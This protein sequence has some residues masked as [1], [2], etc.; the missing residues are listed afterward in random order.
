MRPDF[1]RGRQVWILYFLKLA[2]LFHLD[3]FV[4]L[5]SSREWGFWASRELKRLAT[6]SANWLMSPH[7][8]HTVKKLQVWHLFGHR[9][10]HKN[11][12]YYPCDN[13]MICYCHPTNFLL[14]IHNCPILCHGST[15][16]STDNPRSFI[17]E[18]MTQ[19]GKCFSPFPFL[20]H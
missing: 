16:L 17:V 1:P 3:G 10:T 9:S 15:T 8:L 14:A 11:S 18:I 20:T 5:W 4:S 12:L 6:L 7:H 2:E 19:S 13:Q